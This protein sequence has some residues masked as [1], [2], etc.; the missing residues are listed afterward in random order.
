MEMTKEVRDGRREVEIVELMVKFGKGEARRGTLFGEW[1][2]N[3]HIRRGGAE[4]CHAPR[5]NGRC[6]YQRI[7]RGAPDRCQW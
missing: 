4:T 7:R 5:R 1:R 6:A 3:A 2:R